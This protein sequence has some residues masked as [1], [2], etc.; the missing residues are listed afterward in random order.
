VVG[1]SDATGLTEITM[2]R[3]GP[4]RVCPET[5]RVARPSAAARHASRAE[6]GLRGLGLK[7][8][9]ARRTCRRLL[10][11][12][13]RRLPGPRSDARSANKALAPGG[14]ELVGIVG[15]S[16]LDWLVSDASRGDRRSHAWRYGR[17]R[18]QRWLTSRLAN[19]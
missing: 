4:G 17:R 19:P 7:Q 1:P 6:L 8:E 3:P 5:V 14:S 11:V 2:P 15:L 12:R 10:F 18:H 16:N 9:R 13:S